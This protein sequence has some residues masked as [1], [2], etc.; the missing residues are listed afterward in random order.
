MKGVSHTFEQDVDDEDY[1][2]SYTPSE[3]YSADSVSQSAILSAN[4][5]S[6]DLPDIST[7]G[8]FTYSVRFTTLPDG[9]DLSST[10]ELEVPIQLPL[11]GIVCQPQP[12]P[13]NPQ[14]HQ[15]Q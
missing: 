15:R 11:I 1:Y 7:P 6:S 2:N 13:V 4:F 12:A 5:V 9:T 10:Y 14:K 8:R 3:W